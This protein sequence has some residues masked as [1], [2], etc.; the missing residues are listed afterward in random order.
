MMQPAY[1]T[2]LGQAFATLQ[3][4]PGDPSKST[5]SSSSLPVF[6][7]FLSH[8]SISFWVLIFVLIFLS[9]PLPSRLTG[10]CVWI[11]VITLMPHKHP[12]IGLSRLRKAHINRR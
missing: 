5:Q 3:A 10:Y 1:Q 11:W 2:C 9:H 8:S 4:G 6:L 12:L 7:L